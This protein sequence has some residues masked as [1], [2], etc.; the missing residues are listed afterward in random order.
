MTKNAI[1]LGSLFGIPV[2]VHISWFLIFVL[3]TWSLAGA[4][5]P[6]RYPHWSSGLYWGVGL[7]TSLL[8]FVSVLL[9]E[10]AHSLVARWIGIPVRHITLFIFGGVAQIAREPGSPGAEFFMSIVG[11]L[12]SLALAGL[13]GVG[14][15]LSR[16]ANE[17]LAALTFYLT[18]INAGLAFF[19][20]LPGFP[21]DGGR[22][23]RSLL[24]AWHGD[25]RQ[26]TRIVSLAGQGLAYL[27]ILTGIWQ[28]FKGNWSGGLWIAF[29][30]WFLDNAAQ[31]SYRQVALRSLL[32]GHTVREVMTR[33][34][35]PL[36]PEITL[37][38][39]INEY[40]LGT[41]R[42]CFPVVD[43]GHL[44]GLMTLHNIKRIPREHWPVTTVEVAMT[45]LAELRAIGPDVELWSALQEMTEE[46]V[47]QLPVVEEGQLLGMLGRDNILTFLR[48][49]AELGL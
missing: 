14:W 5:F 21:L 36:P 26:A 11:P 24:W 34:C 39:V 32:D 43:Q 46:G 22:V 29:I 40:L 37:E 2:R 15:L 7:A 20:I 16:G 28:I 38:K 23:L 33:E 31:T 4:Y 42:R 12:T 10:L 49:K 45:P 19:N 6:Q 27:F 1:R 9:H 41:G 13:F 48:T 25:F 35:Y 8:F 18:G 44:R 47:N 30:G 3:V 17:V